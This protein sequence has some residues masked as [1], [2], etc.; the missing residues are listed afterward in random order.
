MD[1]F[2]IV[3]TSFYNAPN[4]FLQAFLQNHIVLS[5]PFAVFVQRKT[6]GRFRE[7]SLTVNR[8]TIS[9][10][11]LF[12]MINFSFL[13]RS[14]CSDIN[15]LTCLKAKVKEGQILFLTFHISR[16][17]CYGISKIEMCSK[18][19]YTAQMPSVWYLLYFPQ[20]IARR[21]V[22]GETRLKTLFP[23]CWRGDLHHR[24]KLSV[25]PTSLVVSRLT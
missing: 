8:T 12:S 7:N 24:L 21:A 25:N 2:F 9:I 22:H 16:S 15:I 23:R 6:A 17:L 1:S 18:I 5:L 10:L 4:S 3:S 19:A 13:N 11:V 20:Q 14:I